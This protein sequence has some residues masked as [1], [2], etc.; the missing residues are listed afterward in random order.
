ML[1]QPL[2]L[3]PPLFTEALYLYQICYHTFRLTAVS[4][5]E[6]YDRVVADALYLSYRLR[7]F[8]A[9]NMLRHYE[10]LLRSF[11]FSQLSRS[12][13]TLR[14][15]AIAATEPPVYESGYD[16]PPDL[17]K[18][19]AATR[20]FSR[21]DTGVLLD[22]QWDLWQFDK[23]WKLTPTAVTLGCFAPAFESESEDHIRIDFGIDT[24]FLPQPDLPNHL[25]M[26][27]SNVRSLLHL[28]HELDRLFVAERRSLWTESGDNF[29]ERLQSALESS[30]VGAS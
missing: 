4:G 6:R 28:V 21:E 9:A 30:D 29:A 16:N 24:H 1:P 12:A 17:D 19:V 2:I 27:R 11:P 22:T 26:T 3:A 13:S 18:I 8:T 15:H 25:F 20:E 7:G 5:D 23:D 10:K 14:V